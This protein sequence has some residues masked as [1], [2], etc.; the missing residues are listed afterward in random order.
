MGS[1]IFHLHPSCISAGSVIAVIKLHLNSASFEAWTRRGG[2][3][4]RHVITCLQNYERVQGK[5]G[6]SKISVKWQKGCHFPCYFL[7]WFPPFTAVLNPAGNLLQR[8]FCLISSLVSADPEICK[9]IGLDVNKAWK[10]SPICS[11]LE[12]GKNLF[13]CVRTSFY[14]GWALADNQD[15]STTC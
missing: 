13:S 9:D 10:I 12:A 8:S 4:I 5:K 11:I 1:E 15:G 6:K 2:L 3:Y 14:G 7:G